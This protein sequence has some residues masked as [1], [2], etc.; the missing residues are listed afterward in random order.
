MTYVFLVVVLIAIWHFV[1]D[2]I[3]APSIRQRYRNELFKIRDQLRGAKIEGIAKSDERAFWFVH[4]GVDNFL[5]RL[6]SLTLLRARS[7]SVEYDSNESLRKVLKG[8]LDAVRDCGDQRIKDAFDKTNSIIEKA[9]IVNFG[10]WFIYLIPL[11]CLVMLLS[12]LSTLAKNL[13]V[14]PHRDVERLIPQCAS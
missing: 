2:G 8:H 14:A 7:L 9:M 4:D 5:D 12:K 10:G 1:Y 6:P 3:I 13:A 11:A